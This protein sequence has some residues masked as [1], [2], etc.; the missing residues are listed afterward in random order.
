MFTEGQKTR[1]IAALNSGTAKR[2]NL[3]TPSNLAFT[4]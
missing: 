3:W 1:M 4:G 2:N